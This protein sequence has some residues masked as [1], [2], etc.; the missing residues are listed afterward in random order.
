MKLGVHTIISKKSLRV[1]QQL[2]C[3]YTFIN[4]SDLDES[5]I[6]MVYE[7]RNRDSVRVWMFDSKPVKLKEHYNF[8]ASLRDS[9]SKIYLLVVRNKIPIGVYNLVEISDGK[10]Q[11][12]FYLFENSKEK[13]LGLEFL[14]YCLKYVFENLNINEIYGYSLK[15]NR[16]A[17][18]INKYLGF[19]FNET[20]N[21]LLYSFL[22]KDK[23]IADI[24]EN[25]KI[26]N[27]LKY[28]LINH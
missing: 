26:L 28:T 5:L 24:I 27:L 20:N 23:F 6:N 13:N 22:R 25:P 11:G 3:N 18:S 15:A 2:N 8:I 17:N 7:E 19:E 9:N 1:L 14:Y 10:A 12:G 4:F 21:D 16:N